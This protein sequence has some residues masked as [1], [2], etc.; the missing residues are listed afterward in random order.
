MHQQV[1]SKVQCACESK[2]YN[3]INQQNW[4]KSKEGNALVL[5]YKEYWLYKG[6]FQTQSVKKEPTTPGLQ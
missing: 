2:S 3:Q 4:K 1:W 6:K 5:L